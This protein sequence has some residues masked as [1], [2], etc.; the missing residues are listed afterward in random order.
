MES[1]KRIKLPKET[2]AL[3]NNIEKIT[4]KVD[5][6]G[7]IKNNTVFADTVL[8]NISFVYKPFS[9]LIH[10]RNGQANM[11]GETLYLDKITSSVSSMPVFIN[12]KLSNIYS[13]SPDINL[14][15]SAK[16]TQIFFD[17]FFNSK[18]VYP[19]KA[20]GNI[21]LYTKLSG[22][23]NALNAKTKLSLGENASLYYMGATIAGAPTGTFNSEEM[24]T[25]PV[26]IHSDVTLYPN[27]VRIKSLKYTL[28]LLFSFL[29]LFL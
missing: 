7:K 9:S 19:I 13:D 1:D 3:V 22:S 27:K 18:S 29:L 16:L 24:T 2:A 28:K 8:N 12:G 6:T 5:I 10:V 25:N 26:A 17:R 23:L 11:R 21:N 14:A 15:V 4:G 20:K